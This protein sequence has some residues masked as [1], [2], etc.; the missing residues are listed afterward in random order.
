MEQYFHSVVL[1]EDRCMGCTN[2]MQRCPM[3]AIRV[4]DRKA[5]ISKDRCIDCGEC[6][7]VCPYHAHKSITDNIKSIDSY[8]YKVA[9][10]PITLYSQ[11]GDNIRIDKVFEGI[12]NLGFDYVYDESVFA[13][14]S[15]IMIKKVIE[16]KEPG[17][18][19][20]ISSHCPAIIRL[21]QTKF[22]E[23]LDN[24]LNIES[25]VE[26]GARLIRRELKEELGCT[27]DEIGIL[28]LSP[29]P[30]RVTSIKQPLGVHFS[31]LNGAISF[32]K[33]YGDILRNIKL[34]DENQTYRKGNLS[35]IRWGYIGGQSEAIGVDKNI[36]V[37]GV[38]NVI[39]VLE[40]VEMGKLDN[41]KYI[42]AS[43][44]IGGCVGGPLNI[45]NPYIAKSK[46]KHLEVINHGNLK[47]N[48]ELVI[49]LLQSGFML[50]DKEIVPK[51]ITQLDDNFVEAM[52]KIDRI[53]KILKELPGLDC[54]SCGAPSCRA[55]AE[56]I[57][58]GYAK[59][60]ECKFI[61]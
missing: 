49:K 30:A 31:A 11:F 61:K 17:S 60:E 14:I 51:E 32:K 59:I 6:I 55:F 41:L 38:F 10:A 4:K 46:L 20:I 58:R 54:G 53:D 15:S 57:V 28:Y 56:D 12:K 2:C 26:I 18:G 47:Y 27:D 21:I 34:T 43:A 3:E 35:G 25:T 22:P 37:D 8:K 48:E 29:C 7:K 52:K 40:A 33:I 50:W 39:E 9:L 45:E 16:K 44:C 1:D 36:A 13:D 23:L 24:L 5:V 19:P 42:E